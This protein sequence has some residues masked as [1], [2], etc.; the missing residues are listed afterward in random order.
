MLFSLFM[1]EGIFMGKINYKFIKANREQVDMFIDTRYTHLQEKRNS[2]IGFIVIDENDNIIAHLVAEEKIMPFPLG[3][4]DWFIW[5]IFVL[6]ELRRKGIATI[7]LNET[8]KC[9]EQTNV[10]HL[11][12]SCINTPAHLFWFKHN[13]CF[14]I[15]GQKI[16]KPNN[17]HEHGNYP[18]WIFY[19]L[20][21][22]ENGNYRQQKNYR[23]IRADKEQLNWIFNEH[24][25][26]KFYHGKRE[27]TFGLTA[28][29][30]D[31]NILGFIT[32]YADG[33]G[34]PL[35]GIQWVIPYIYVRPDLRRQR[36]AFSLISEIIQSAK[37]ANVTQLTCFN[38]NEEASEFW[39]NNNFDICVHYFSK[40]QEG[41]NPVSAALRIL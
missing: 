7:L 1:L 6:P 23:I 20:N 17:P 38:L 41:K 22:K 16:D 10:R 33:L 24:I 3:G 14:I 30:K 29:D 4:T 26:S 31:N 25:H 40:T 8:I 19:R 21:K 15:Y 32:A 36:I 39:H 37:E 34:S 9:A 5:N 27:D 12:G 18:H 28:V 11:L 35:E 2:V 13:F